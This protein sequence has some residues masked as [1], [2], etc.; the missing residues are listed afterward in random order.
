MKLRPLHDRV[1]VKRVEEEKV[2][3][4]G[5][6][7]PDNVAEKPIRGKVIAVGREAKEYIGRTPPNISAL[8]PLKDG[9]IADFDVT[10]AMIKYFLTVVRKDRKIQKPKMVVGVPSGITMVAVYKQG[11]EGQG[12]PSDIM[13]VR[14]KGGYSWANVLKDGNGIPNAQNV[15]SPTERTDR[16]VHSPLATASCSTAWIRSGA[17]HRQTRVRPAERESDR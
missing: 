4:G 3:A 11:M 17:T 7:I 8:R 14:A 13:M 5:I 1:I 2:S 15:S 9:V 12:G 16:K 10:K 6:V